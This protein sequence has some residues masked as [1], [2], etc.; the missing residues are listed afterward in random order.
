MT[1]TNSKLLNLACTRR[2]GVVHEF[3][4]FPVRSRYSVVHVHLIFFFFQVERA[5]L[6]KHLRKS[7]TIPKMLRGNKK[8]EESIHH[9]NSKSL[10]FKW[11]VGH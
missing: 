10:D 6:F 11:S 5:G 9:D 2:K 1:D 7:P 3:K 4:R 8:T